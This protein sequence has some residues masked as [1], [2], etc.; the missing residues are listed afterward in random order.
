M[1]ILMTKNAKW[2]QEITEMIFRLDDL[3]HQRRCRHQ[4]KS[5][6]DWTFRPV[7]SCAFD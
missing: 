5:H 3:Q 4:P 1:A 2:Y 6:I 7:S